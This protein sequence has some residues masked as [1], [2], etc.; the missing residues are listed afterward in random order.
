MVKFGIP[1]L[2]VLILVSRRLT[3]LLAEVVDEDAPGWKGARML[4]AA[5]RVEKETQRTPRILKAHEPFKVVLLKQRQTDDLVNFVQSSR[6]L[7]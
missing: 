5:E 7:C 6:A 1:I 2:P 4:R 3:S